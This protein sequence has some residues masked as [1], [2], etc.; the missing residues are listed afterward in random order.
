M[1]EKVDVSI[2]GESGLGPSGDNQLVSQP[3]G[4]VVDQMEVGGEDEGPV[5]QTT[6]HALTLATPRKSALK[7]KTTPRISIDQLL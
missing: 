2:S 7:T 5:A 1:G 4:G 3:G 6:D